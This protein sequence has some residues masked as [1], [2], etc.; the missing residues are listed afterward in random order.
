LKNADTAFFHICSRGKQ[1]LKEL[2]FIHEY[3]NTLLV[4][5]EQNGICYRIPYQK[6]SLTDVAKAGLF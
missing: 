2:Y 1:T 6:Q 4:G 5:E 3:C